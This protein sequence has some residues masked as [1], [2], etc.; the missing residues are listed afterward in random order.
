MRNI[1]VPVADALYELHQ[2]IGRTEKNY[3]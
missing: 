2:T 3:V 1:P